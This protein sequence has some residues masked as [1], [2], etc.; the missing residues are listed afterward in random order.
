M[1][2]VTEPGTPTFGL[3]SQETNEEVIADIKYDLELISE[4]L[5]NFLKAEAEK[6][7]NNEIPGRKSHES[8]ITFSDEVNEKHLYPLEGYL[9][10]SSTEQ[11][12]P[13][14]TEEKGK[15][16]MRGLFKKSKKRSNFR[17]DDEN[18]KKAAVENSTAR[19]L[20][21]KMQPAPPT[22]PKFFVASTGCV[23]KPHLKVK[24]LNKIK[25]LF[26][27]KIH[28]EVDDP[29]KEPGNYGKYENEEILEKSKSAFR[30]RN[31]IG[32]WA[33]LTSG[34]NRC[35]KTDIK[36]PPDA[37]IKRISDLPTKEIVTCA[38]REHWIKTDAEYFVLELKENG[39]VCS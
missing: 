12:N 33:S 25:S 9:L 31:G 13:M 30:K 1:E 35:S 39:G 36:L 24:K 16:F 38:G 6:E 17:E 23:E 5:E 22:S 14:E 7:G 26:H 11:C 32:C 20:T 19:Y 3:P 18:H 27:K 21:N 34:K 10:R 4:N 2:P 8:T 37:I 28:P 15:M 29:E